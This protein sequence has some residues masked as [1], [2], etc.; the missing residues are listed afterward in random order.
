[1][2]F[3][4]SWL[5]WVRLHYLLCFEV[6]KS[7]GVLLLYYIGMIGLNIWIFIM[8][9]LR[10]GLGLQMVSSLFGIRLGLLYLVQ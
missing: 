1:M 9:I 5:N 10:L 6:V 3:L 2:I 7:R 8:I 4:Y